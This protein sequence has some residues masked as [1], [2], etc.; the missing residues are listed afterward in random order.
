MGRLSPT[1]LKEET[2]Q[3]DVG[4]SLEEDLGLNYRYCLPNK[5][6]DY[7]HGGIPV[8]VTDLPLLRNLV[9]TYKIG[10]V[11][12]NRDPKKLAT[13]IDHVVKNKKSYRDNLQ[14]AAKQLN[15]N[16]EKIKLKKIV[17]NIK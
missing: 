4:L 10:E 11:L 8:I 15:W 16:K 1:E 2:K 13:V 7:I 5:V 6:F 3:S 17:K 9:D 14:V 12:V